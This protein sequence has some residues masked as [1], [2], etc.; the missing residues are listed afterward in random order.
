M[1]NTL[2]DLKHFFSVCLLVW[3]SL[4]PLSTLFQIYRGGKFYWWRKPEDPGKPPQVTDK[5]YHIMLYTSA[6]SRFEL[7][8]LVVIGTDCIG[9][10]YIQQSYDHGHDGPPFFSR[11]FTFT[12]KIDICENVALWVNI[13]VAL[14]WYEITLV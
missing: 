7:T 8:T 5:L 1:C 12:N 2:C 10:F 14:P 9:K 6:W 3:W 4:T 11:Y 13:L